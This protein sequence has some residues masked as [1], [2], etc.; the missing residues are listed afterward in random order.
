MKGAKSGIKDLLILNGRVQLQV[1]LEIS[2]QTNS[3]EKK[4]N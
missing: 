3:R 1:S 4:K 2:K